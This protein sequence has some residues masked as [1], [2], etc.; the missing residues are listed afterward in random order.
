MAVTSNTDK[1]NKAYKFFYRDGL[2]NSFLY[3]PLKKIQTLDVVSMGSYFPTREGVYTYAYNNQNKVLTPLQS[4]EDNLYINNVKY[5]GHFSMARFILPFSG[6]K[7]Q[8]RQNKFIKCSSKESEFVQFT[9]VTS[10]SPSFW[11]LSFDKGRVKTLVSW[12]LKNY[13]QKKTI[14]LV[15]NLKNIGF[16]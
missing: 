10:K 13:G 9:T 16:E 5:Y 11:N 3:F 7:Y 1:I 4:N 8:L 15:E 6:R 2:K 14:Q 12:F